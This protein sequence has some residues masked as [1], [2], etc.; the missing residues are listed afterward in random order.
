MAMTQTQILLDMLVLELNHP[1]TWVVTIIAG[2]ITGTV[3]G[4]FQGYLIGY[5]MIPAFIVT[6]GGLLVWLNVACYMTTGQTIGPLD[7]TFMMLGGINGT[8]A[9]LDP[10]SSALRL[11]WTPGPPSSA[12]VGTKRGMDFR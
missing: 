3:I 10:G 5:L 11:L 6:L 4:A 8:L 9:R 7:S 1:I 2:I 12:L